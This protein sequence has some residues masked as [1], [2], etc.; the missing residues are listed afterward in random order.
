M[1]KPL[2]L[3]EPVFATLQSLGLGVDGGDACGGGDRCLSL[4]ES[5]RHPG[6]VPAGHQQA[7]GV[8]QAG[9]ARWGPL[10]SRH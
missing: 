5:E 3:A 1:C 8:H 4:S 7:E 2:G 6:A 9:H 10:G